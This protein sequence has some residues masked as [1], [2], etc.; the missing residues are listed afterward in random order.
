VRVS[1][2]ALFPCRSRGDIFA[3]LG[4]Y[5]M[6]IVNYSQ[7]IKLNPD[8]EKTYFQRASIFEKTGMLYFDASSFDN[9]L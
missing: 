2:A 3:S 8:D 1:Q 5:T 7:T 6:A 4:D 9:G